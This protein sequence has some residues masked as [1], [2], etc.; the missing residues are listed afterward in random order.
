MS[1]ANIASLHGFYSGAPREMVRVAPADVGERRI[2]HFGFF[3]ER[4]AKNLWETHM[5][6]ALQ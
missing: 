6:P 2:G 5:W 3:R 1:A 4:Y